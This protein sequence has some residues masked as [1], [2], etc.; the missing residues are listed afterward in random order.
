M[1]LFDSHSHFD[2]A[3]FDADRDGAY[4]RA[5]EAGVREQ[6]LPAITAACWP[7]LKEVASGYPGVY[8]SYGLHPMYL[9][10]HRP[11]HLD[12]L[13]QWLDRERPV[14]VGECGLDFYVKDLD[15]EAQTLFFR[16]QLELARQFDLPVI[17]HARRSVDEVTKQIRRV[18]GSRGVVHSFS[19]SEQQAR[20]LIDLGFYLS[21]GGPIT[22]ERANRLRDLVRRLPLESILIETDSPDQPDSSHRGERN[23]PSYL[24]IVLYELARLRGEDPAAVAA[25]TTANARRLFGLSAGP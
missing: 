8:P 24:P 12:A 22:F 10:E 6:V 16:A 20:I 21:F 4:A 9:E 19:G 15:P 11:D 17:I 5:V 18:P 23:E 13:E 14:A 2:V 7:Q 1:E 25:A 3:A